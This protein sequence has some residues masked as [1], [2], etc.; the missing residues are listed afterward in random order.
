MFSIYAID[1]IY[2][3]TYVQSFKV[4]FYKFPKKNCTDGDKERYSRM[5]VKIFGWFY[6]NLK[7]FKGEDLTLIKVL[8][9]C[10]FRKGFILF[11]GL[12]NSKLYI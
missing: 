7:R 6:S 3:Y 4:L 8:D 10:L 1:Y 11:Y 9:P 12:V 5:L 2:M